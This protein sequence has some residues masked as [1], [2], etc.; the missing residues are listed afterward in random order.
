MTSS[1]VTVGTTATLIVAADDKHRTVYLHVAGNST[2]YLGNASATTAN[3]L[4]TEKNTTPLE[5]F[6]PLRE[7]L[8]GIVAS[9]TEVVRVLTPDAD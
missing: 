9:D 2:V 3:G 1:S 7:T 4:S 6:L 5:I 8:Y